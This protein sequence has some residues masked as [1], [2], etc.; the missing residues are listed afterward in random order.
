MN[1]IVSKKFRKILNDLKRRPEDA[2]KDLKLSLRS[3]NKILNGT[4]D[5]NYKI[6]DK[7]VSVWPVNH[8]DFFYTQ[9]DTMNNIKVCKKKFSDK[10]ARKMYR[11]NIPY[12]LYKDTVMSKVSTFRPEWIQQLLTVQDSDPNNIR[13]KFNNGHF[14]HQFTYFIGPVNFYYIDEN[15]K[16]NMLEMNTG[17][18]MYISPYTPHS[19]TTRKNKNNLKGLILAL[20]YTDKIDNDALN[21]L[22]SIGKDLSKDFK[23]NLSDKSSSIKNIISNFLSISSMTSEYL[24]KKIQF[25]IDTAVKEFTLAKVDKLSKIA[26]VLNVNLRDLIPLNNYHD[27]KTTKYSDANFWFLPSKTSKEL[28]IVELATV[29]HLPNSKALEINILKKNFFSFKVPS[30]QYI[31][32]IGKKPCVI[33][34]SGNLQTLEPGD[35]CYVKP[36]L[37]HFFATKGKLLILRIGGKISSEN[38]LHFSLLNE[39]KLNRL[40]DDNKSWFN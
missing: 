40:L 35:S 26:D 31:Y 17:D 4:K 32:N 3:I 37:R 39:K 11:D 15:D 9:D 16:K 18:S 23:I 6:I 2:A 29:N 30:H 19:F 13:V 33:N 7:A 28:K 27:V 22:N 14:L 36:N 20:T 1:Y 10:T 12:Y 5:L 25:K 21:E 8:S 34:F 24:E 38:L